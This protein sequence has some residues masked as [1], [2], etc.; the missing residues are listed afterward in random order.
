MAYRVTRNIWSHI[1]KSIWSDCVWGSL[2]QKFRN[3]L[4]DP[5]SWH[6]QITQIVPQTLNLDTEHGKLWTPVAVSVSERPF[7]LTWRWHRSWW[8]AFCCHGGSARIPSCLLIG[9]IHREKCD[10]VGQMGRAPKFTWWSTHMLST[11]CSS[12]AQPSFT[13][14]CCT[15][16]KAT[17]VAKDA[18]VYCL[19]L[20]ES[21]VVS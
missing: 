5:C 1:T 3:S 13:Q 20:A 18:A 14:T 16:T 9:G 6:N 8:T 11:A 10:P 21:S 15:I 17:Q 2:S 12:G 4:K 7:S 19:W